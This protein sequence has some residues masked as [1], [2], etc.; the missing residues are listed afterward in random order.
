MSNTI[1]YE[2]LLEMRAS[3]SVTQDWR[4]T[5]GQNLVEPPS[6]YRILFDMI[7]NDPVLFTAIDLTVDMV[8]YNGYD[9]VGESE[10]EIKSARE[11]FEQELDFDQVLKNLL[12]QLLPFGDAFMEVRERDGKVTE[13]YPLPTVEMAIKYDSTGAITGYRQRPYNSMTGKPV[14]FKAD[15]VIF[16]RLYW[17]GNRVYSYS[18]LEPTIRGYNSKIFANNFLQQL[19]KNLHPKVIYFLKTA[20]KEARDEFMQNVIRAKMNPNVDIVGRGEGFDVK[21]LQYAFDTGLTDIL[22]Y[23]REEVLMVT[24]VPKIWI[25]MTESGN[26]STAEVQLIPIETRV[27]KIQ[28]I[29]SS[30]INRQ[31]MKRVGFENLRFKFNPISLMDEKAIFDNAQV[32]STLGLTHDE[33]DKHP[34]IVYLRSHGV[35]IAKG[36][37]V[38]TMP[39]PDNQFPSRKGASPGDKMTSNINKKGVSEE[40]GQK[41]QS[42]KVAKTA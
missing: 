12:F 26:R 28:Q 7:R 22:D 35:N 36:T 25:G 42:A 1:A 34:I 23:L 19:F 29:I 40:S 39:T 8:T 18:Q 6:D 17:I 20:N 2:T 21:L 5:A 10:D 41:L 27:K 32:L 9:F 3:R 4:P 15:E 31:L 38:E 16:F 33:N 11:F 24:R 13:V 14:D 37:K 30:Y